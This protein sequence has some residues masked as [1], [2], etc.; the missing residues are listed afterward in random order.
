MHIGGWAAPLA[1][2]LPCLKSALGALV[3]S[4]PAGRRSAASSRSSNSMIQIRLSRLHS[5]FV[6]KTEHDYY[7]SIVAILL[8]KSCI[9]NRV[10][11]PREGR[12]NTGATPRSVR[13]RQAGDRDPASRDPN[14][15]PLE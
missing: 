13:S 8:C 7:S 2:T 4:P 12:G 11:L 14:P 9:D 5:Y 1:L 15:E 6:S 3:F 10:L